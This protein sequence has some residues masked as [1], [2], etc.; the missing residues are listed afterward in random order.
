MIDLI[1][2]VI[3]NEVYV[4]LS[5]YCLFQRSDAYKSIFI[6]M[7]AHHVICTSYVNSFAVSPFNF[8]LNNTAFIYLVCCI[9]LESSSTN[10]KELLVKDCLSA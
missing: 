7:L 10:Q 5:T 6:C 1:N 2:L 9:L 4:L 8:T 3:A